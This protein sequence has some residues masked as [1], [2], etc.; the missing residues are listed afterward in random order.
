MTE[1]FKSGD[2]VY[3]VK[4]YG[5]ARYGA[6]A[7]VGEPAYTSLG[8]LNVSWDR[9]NGLAGGQ[10]SGGY[11][12]DRFVLLRGAGPST[13]LNG[14]DALS[15]LAK[16][17]VDA[18]AAFTV[19]SHSD[20]PKEPKMQERFL[21]AYK[22][23]PDFNLTGDNYFNTQRDAD[24]HANAIA[25]VEADVTVVVLKI[26]SSHSSRIVVTSEAA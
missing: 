1:K 15:D 16:K 18:P 8:Y 12:E 13:Y 25:A 20:N 22:D 4:P 5:T 9:Q 23:G 10:F 26:V 3:M 14:L 24:N 2:T 19:G 17:A 7:V 11:A 6:V 21:T